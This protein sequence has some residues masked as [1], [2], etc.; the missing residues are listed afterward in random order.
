MGS[1][2]GPLNG[3]GVSGGEGDTLTRVEN[4]DSEEVWFPAWGIYA[5]QYEGFLVG[6]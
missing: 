3:T 6:V 2:A 4:W 1:P 5:S